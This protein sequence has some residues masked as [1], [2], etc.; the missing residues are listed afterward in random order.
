M[1]LRSRA[2][3]EHNSTSLSTI[4]G[5]CGHNG[6]RWGR[7]YWVRSFA[8]RPAPSCPSL[9]ASFWR[10]DINKTPA[11][12]RAERENIEQ[13]VVTLKRLAA[14]RGRCRS[15]PPTWMTALKRRGRL[16]KSAARSRSALF[17]Q[18]IRTVRGLI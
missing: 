14:G 2:A 1:V 9:R 13:A 7:S 10:M 18:C 17:D 3:V 8:Y 6:L 16:M 5:P 4:A 12:L 15:R 11:E